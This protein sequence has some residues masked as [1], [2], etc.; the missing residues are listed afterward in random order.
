MRRAGYENLIPRAVPIGD[1]FPRTF[2]D[3]K[4]PPKPPPAF[5][6][7]KITQDG[8]YWG[9]FALVLWVHDGDLLT[10]AVVPRVS[11]NGKDDNDRLLRARLCS[12]AL[13][14]LSF[15]STTGHYA[16][17]T[18]R[19]TSDGFEILLAQCSHGLASVEA[20]RDV[21]RAFEGAF[22][23]PPPTEHPEHPAPKTDAPPLAEWATLETSGR[24][25]RQWELQRLGKEVAVI[26]GNSK[27]YHGRLVG[28]NRDSAT[29]E[30]GGRQ[31][32][33]MVIPL[34]SL[35]LL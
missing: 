12:Q 26:E 15:D 34:Q 5:S 22:V 27:G 16:Y 1:T 20:P 35:V 3:F 32:P 8:L 31:K 4:D 13:W 7:V 28:F 19:F 18:R 21:V 24:L 2:F 17:G 30:F 23:P 10:L 9:D 25:V 33:T 11:F 6:F 14:G 29:V